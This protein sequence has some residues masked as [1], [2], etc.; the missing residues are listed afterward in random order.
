MWKRPCNVN[1]FV[2]NRTVPAFSLNCYWNLQWYMT[3]HVNVPENFRDILHV[4]K[5]LEKQGTN[6][7]NHRIFTVS[8]FYSKTDNAIHMCPTS[9]NQCTELSQI[10]S[11]PLIHDMMRPN[12]VTRP[13]NCEDAWKSHTCRPPQH[14]HNRTVKPGK[15][16]LFTWHYQ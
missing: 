15:R 4:W 12:W 7:A 5:R 8:K 13:F 1:A 9:S 6:T 2:H 11:H 10:S 3:P 16:F 14:G